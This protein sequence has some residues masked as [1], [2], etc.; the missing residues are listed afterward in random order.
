MDIYKARELQ[1]LRFKQSNTEYKF[2]KISIMNGKM[3][4]VIG[5]R[6]CDTTLIEMTIAD[7]YRISMDVKEGVHY[8]VDVMTEERLRRASVPIRSPTGVYIIEF[9]EID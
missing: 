4:Y 7:A 9:I 3:Y 1:K 5:H 6:I 8:L 2:M